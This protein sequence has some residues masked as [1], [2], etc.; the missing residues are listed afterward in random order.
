MS[1]YKQF[2][3]ELFRQNDPQAR[4]VVLSHLDSLGLFAKENDDQYGPD[5]VLYRGL[6]PISYIEVEVKRV[7]TEEA[8]PWDS[9]QLPLRKEK[10]TKLGLPCEFWIINSPLQHAIIIPDT[11]L[12]SSFV[13]EIPNRYIKSGEKFYQIPLEM[14]IRKEL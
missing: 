6:K 3:P 12:S 1:K 5:I 13:K 14:C 9:I 10:F 7:W 2:D 4:D 8:F 11:A